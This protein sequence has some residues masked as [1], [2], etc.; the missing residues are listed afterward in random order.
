MAR[1]HRS[2]IVICVV[3]GGDLLRFVAYDIVFS[4]ALYWGMK[5]CHLGELASFAGSMVIPTAMRKTFHLRK[6]GS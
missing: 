1:R 2:E 4:S 6:R 5:K 3:N